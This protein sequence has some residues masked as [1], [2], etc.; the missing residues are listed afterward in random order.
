MTRRFTLAPSALSE[1]SITPF[2]GTLALSPSFTLFFVPPRYH[3]YILVYFI[4]A[5]SLMLF[6]PSTFEKKWS[7]T[8]EEER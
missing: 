8:K 4:S 5:T 2:L 1:I 3:K 6:R 7:Q